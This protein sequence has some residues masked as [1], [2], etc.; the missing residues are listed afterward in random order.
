MFDFHSLETIPT[1]SKKNNLR[2]FTKS[3]VAFIF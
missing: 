2:L 3:K 1:S